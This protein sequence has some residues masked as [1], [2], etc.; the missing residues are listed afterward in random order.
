M[1]VCMYILFA[2]RYPI[3]PSEGTRFAARYIDCSVDRSVDR[4]IGRSIAW[5]MANPNKNRGSF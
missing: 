1:Y 3:N 4:S 2:S 5:L